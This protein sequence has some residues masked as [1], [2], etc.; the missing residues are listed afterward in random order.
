MATRYDPFQELDRLTGQVLGSARAATT[1]PMDLYRSGDHYVINVD[2]PGADPGTIEVTVEDRMLTI[3][4]E[5]TLGSQQDVQ[6]L[7]HERPSGTYARQLTVGSGL[8]LDSADA[9]YADGVLT[10]SI[11]LGTEVK[12]RKIEVQTGRQPAQIR[13]GPKSGH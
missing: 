4:A 13:T 12:A 3:R 11:P 10:L 1:M 2:L 7:T 8:A 5:R 6:W 9:T